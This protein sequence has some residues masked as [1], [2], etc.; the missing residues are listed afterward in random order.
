M[1]CWVW[2]LVWCKVA[3][4]VFGILKCGTQLMVTGQCGTSVRASVRNSGLGLTATESI[5]VHTVASSL[6]N[7]AAGRWLT[8]S[9]DHCEPEPEL[10]PEP[11]ATH[12]VG[13]E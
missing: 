3:M 6:R 8:L 11:T 10:E 12:L 4:M 2:A 13:S 5:R 1:C 7:S 9:H